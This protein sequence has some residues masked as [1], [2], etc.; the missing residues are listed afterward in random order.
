MKTFNIL[1]SISSFRTVELTVI[2]MKCDVIHI[3]SCV[4]VRH[5]CGDLCVCVCFFEFKI[6]FMN[7]F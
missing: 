5:D 4:F 7:A 3:T 1:V 2:S 6:D